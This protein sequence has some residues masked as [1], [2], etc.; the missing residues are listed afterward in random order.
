[1]YE[2]CIKRSGT[3]LKILTSALYYKFKLQSRAVY[4]NV[5]AIASKWSEDVAIL[6]LGLVLF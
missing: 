6:M 3:L 2:M 4:S 5:I 1:M